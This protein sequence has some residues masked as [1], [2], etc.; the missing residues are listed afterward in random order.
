VSTRRAGA[1][2]SGHI[3]PVAVWGG[4]AYPSA[5]ESRRLRRLSGSA[6]AAARRAASTVDQR[7]GHGRWG[8]CRSGDCRTPRGRVEQ[9]IVRDVAD[10][11]TVTVDGQRDEAIGSCPSVA[12]AVCRLQPGGRS[13]A[14]CDFAR[15]QSRVYR[16]EICKSEVVM[17]AAER[18]NRSGG[19]MRSRPQPGNVRAIIG[20]IGA[21][22]GSK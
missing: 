9:V 20:A 12:A 10:R 18:H 2:R 3:E 22:S 19:L 1:A 7:R 11:A 8:R 16:H 14:P 21:A 15:L 6:R 4:A 13:L 17:I 5:T